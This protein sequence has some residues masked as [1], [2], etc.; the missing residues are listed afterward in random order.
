MDERQS[1]NGRYAYTSGLE[2]EDKKDMRRFIKDGRQRVVV[3][4][5]EAL[6]KGLSDSLTNLFGGA[7][8]FADAARAAETISRRELARV[9]DL[10]D[11]CEEARKRG[12]Q[13][14]VVQSAQARARQAAG[15]LI[16]DTESYLVD[17]RVANA[18]I[19][20]LGQPR[21]GIVSVT[22]IVRGNLVVAEHAG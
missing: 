8:G 17:V 20:G 14:I 5:P 18:L 12:T 3:T 11:R 4:S 7:A 1:P 22:C 21:V 19:S 6:V 15:R 16:T 2:D 10:A 13:A 9:S